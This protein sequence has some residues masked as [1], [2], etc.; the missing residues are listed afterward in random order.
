MFRERV[1][2]SVG[3]RDKL[4]ALTSPADLAGFK[5]VQGCHLSWLQPL[6][7]ATL[8]S[9]A[10]PREKL[11]GLKRL[12]RLQLLRLLEALGLFRGFLG[13]H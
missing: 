5:E 9:M 11:I 1:I 13:C 8:N 10:D 2:D 4:L 12:G 6:G 3:R 7:P